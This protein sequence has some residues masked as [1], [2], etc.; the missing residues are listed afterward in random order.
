M[1]LKGDVE[2]KFTVIIIIIIIINKPFSIMEEDS[3]KP[4][5][6]SGASTSETKRY[7]F[8]PLL[9]YPVLLEQSTVLVRIKAPSPNLLPFLNWKQFHSINIQ[10]MCDAQN[11]IL[12]AVARWPGRNSFVL[13]NSLVSMW[14]DQGAA[15]DG[16]LIDKCYDRIFI[17]LHYYLST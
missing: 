17:S 4:V 10:I 3:L 11:H 14:L 9:D 5:C 1:I 2:M 13:H 6:H 8:M 7:N 15:G 16:W 12:N